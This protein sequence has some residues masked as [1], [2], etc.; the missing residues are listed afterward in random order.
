MTGNSSAS[1][2]TSQSELGAKT[3]FKEPVPRN[4]Y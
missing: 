2:L 1:I 4:Q 3:V